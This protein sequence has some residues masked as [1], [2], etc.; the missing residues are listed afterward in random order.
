MPTSKTTRM[1]MIILYPQYPLEGR[2]K[3]SQSVLLSKKDEDILDICCNLEIPLLT[4][5]DTPTSVLAITGNTRATITFNVPS[6]DGGSEITSYTVTSSP[7]GIIASGLSSPIIVSG[8]TNG[9]SYTFTVIATNSLGSSTSSSASNAVTPATVPNAPTSI[10]SSY[11]NTQSTVSFTVPL[12]NGGSPITSYT[13]TSSPGGISACGSSSPIIVFG[14]TNGISY[15]F[16]VVATNNLGDSVPSF[17]SPACTAG[18]DAIIRSLT[19]SLRNYQ[20]A[21]TDDWVKIT[22]TEYTTLQTNISETTKVGGSDA[23]LSASVS[24]G[25]ANHN[26]ALISNSVTTQSPAIPAN[27]Y[28]YAFAVRWGTSEGGVGM[29]VYT[30]T[31]SAGT[32]GFTQVGGVIPTI[33][34]SGLSYYVRKGVSTTNGATAGT[35]ACFTGTK[36]DYSNPNFTGSAGYIGFTTGITPKPIMRYLLGD[37]SVPANSSTLSGSL[38]NYGAFVIQGLTSN[39]KQW[40]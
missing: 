26:S 1:K 28:L 30:N 31:N 25:L 5:P 35:L 9:T 32:N 33:T 11:G 6:S 3:Y 39:T 2:N 17:P 22:S 13:V 36:M 8:L 21:S 10:T 23:V 38:S 4:V 27:N 34:T 15:T 16:T 18:V 37:S 40:A 7:E 12:S 24:G 14:L 20:S 29:R 19:T